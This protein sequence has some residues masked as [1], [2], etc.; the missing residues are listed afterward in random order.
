MHDRNKNDRLEDAMEKYSYNSHF[1]K[2]WR[3]GRFFHNK[4]NDL[5]IAD[6]F[7]LIALS[8]FSIFIPIFLI[9]DA[10]YSILDICF[11]EIASFFAV[12]IL[13]YFTLK[14]LIST[15]VK[16]IL[17]ISYLLN[18]VFL[19]ILYF[20]DTLISDFGRF[21]FLS[22]VYFFGIVPCVFYWSA[23]HVYFLDSIRSA[24]EGKKLGIMTAI[25]TIMGIA[26]PF[27]G[28]ILITQAGFK[29]VFIISAALMVVASGALFFSSDIKIKLNLNFEKIIDLKNMK[30][31]MTYAIQGIGYTA[32]GLIWPLF[33]F[34][35]SI[36]LISMGFLYLFS[37]IASAV[38]YY[39]VGSKTDKPGSKNLGRIGAVGHGLFLILRAIFETI[40]AMTAFQ[41]MGGIFSGVLNT[42]LDSN[43]FKRSHN[44]IGNAIMNRELYM[45]V[46]KIFFVSIFI[47][48]LI[49]MNIIGALVLT[50]IMA[51]VIILTLNI[52]IKYEE[53]SN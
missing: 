6:T 18:I 48:G 51:G 19:L 35:I 25:P 7:R 20:F 32:T 26:S 10:G 30:K 49:F 53:W 27:I 43:F 42:A 8:M 1:S 21:A 34:F 47:V 3:L 45:Y 15:G 41:I 31:N 39:F 52:V 12:I 23:H 38:T 14:Y 29:G 11:F 28:S 24:D 33:L 17:I 5:V 50:L 4:Y 44:D 13:Y 36:K 40:L 2:H 46:G 37:N 9:R 16:R 22:M